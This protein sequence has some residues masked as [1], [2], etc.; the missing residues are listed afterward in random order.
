V[1][2]VVGVAC[3]AE[4]HPKADLSLLSYV[5]GAKVIARGTDCSDTQGAGYTPNSICISY[6]LVEASRAGNSHVLRAAQARFF[7]RK[8]WRRFPGANYAYPDAEGWADNGGHDCVLLGSAK[9]T[10]LSTPMFRP[11]PRWWTRMLAALRQ[12]EDMHA[13]TMGV[14]V[15]PGPA[16][17]P[18][19]KQC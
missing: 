7:A 19:R 3:G 2:W 6:V 9:A 12:L 10:I 1:C 18:N 11:V 13:A 14:I 15:Y 5:D 8:G 16:N 4:S 17:I